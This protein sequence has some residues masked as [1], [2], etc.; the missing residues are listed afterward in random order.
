MDIELLR[1]DKSIETY[2]PDIELPKRVIPYLAMNE[3]GNCRIIESAIFGEYTADE[4]IDMWRDVLSRNVHRISKELMDLE[5]E[6]CEKVGPSSVQKPF[7]ERIPLIRSYYESWKEVDQREL[8]Y[9]D[10]QSHFLGRLMPISPRKAA[11]ELPS[12]TNAGMPEFQRRSETREQDITAVIDGDWRHPAILGWRGQFKGQFSSI[13][14]SMDWSKVLTAQRTVW[15]FSQRTN[16]KETQYSK[17][18]FNDIR[19][20]ES[21]S[22]WSGINHTSKPITEILDGCGEDEDVVGIDYS[23][24]DQSIGPYHQYIV[25]DPVKNAFQKQYWDEID[26]IFQF[27]FSIPLICTKDMMYA[28]IHALSSGSSWTSILGTGVNYRI[29]IGSPSFAGPRFLYLAT[30]DDGVGKFVRLDDHYRWLE[31]WGLTVHPDKQVVSRGGKYTQY[32]QRHYDK[33]HRN[34]NGDIVPIYPGARTFSSLW[35]ER[36]RQGWTKELETLRWMSVVNNSE[37]HPLLL[38]LVKLYVENGDKWAKENVIRMIADPKF[39][40]L[41]KSFPGFIPS[42][43]IEQDLS[44]FKYWPVTRIVLEIG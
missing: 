22:S 13:C 37:H 41:A 30:G 43:T 23:S 6:Q 16:I 36:W 3:R 35:K 7:Y 34:E 8:P 24:F 26:E 9:G 11:D 18:F 29:A 19:Y 38:D 32:L 27:I 10:F 12:N 17:P 21:F 1:D 39:I 40:N 28:G 44:S 5:L 2:T 14:D 20:N 31:S 33:E 4:V 42:Y 25:S 15:M